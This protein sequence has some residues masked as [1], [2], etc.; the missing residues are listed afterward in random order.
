MKNNSF[1]EILEKLKKCKNIAMALHSAP[2]GDSLG[3]CTGMKYF[4]E[5]DLKCKV[6][7]VSYDFFAENLNKLD[8]ASEVE[9]GKDISGLNLAD[10]DCVLFL[11]CGSEENIF[12]KSR[13]NF[14]LN[15][16]KFVINIDHHESNLY[17][18]NLNYVDV[19]APSACSVL[20]DFFKYVGVK[21]DKELSKRLLLG[22]CTDSGFF[23]YDSEP[24][25]A[26]KDAVFLID[27]GADYLADVLRPVLYNQPIKIV[28]YFG[29]LFN[30]L[31][32]DE[33]LRCRYTSISH[34]EVKKLGLN[35]A[36]T[37]LGIN[38]LQFTAECDFVFSLVEFENIIRGSFRSKKGVNVALFAK[39]FGGGG[40]KFAAA[41][42]LE[43]MPLE[44]AEK[45]VLD[46]VRKIGIKRD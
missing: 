10:Y 40:H 24:E 42:F 22:V 37:R 28:K 2:D 6:K 26:L 14:N 18:G 25:K 21:F 43:K 34:E 45:F 33:E 23:E 5:R 19:K 36:E 38:E 35:K 15:K 8:Y 16:A 31:K 1:A 17:Y 9:F 39:E 3:C 44:K 32:F 27:N 30:K 20:I 41:F 12:G 29:L 46:R 11:D 4:L 7:L 13:E